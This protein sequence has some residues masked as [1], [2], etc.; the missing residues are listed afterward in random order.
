MSSLLCRCSLGCRCSLC[1]SRVAPKEAQEPEEPKE[2]QEQTGSVSSVD[3]HIN[4]EVLESET[5]QAW[6][7]DLSHDF[8]IASTPPKVIISEFRDA[9]RLFG[10]NEKVTLRDPGHLGESGEY[11]AIVLLQFD[12]NFMSSTVVCRYPSCYNINLAAAKC[13]KRDLY[14]CPHHQRVLRN[15]ISDALAKESVQSSTSL[16][17]PEPGQFDGYTSL[18]SLLECTQHDAKN[19]YVQEAIL[20]VRNF[21]II[22]STVLNPDYS[23]L[24]TALSVLDILKFILE[25]REDIEYVAEKAIPLLKEVI[26]KILSAFGVVYTWV[27]QTLQNPG[28]PG[29]QPGAQIGAGVGGVIGGMTSF[30][31]GPLGWLGGVAAGSYLGGL[32]GNGIYNLFG[33]QRQQ[34]TERLGPNRQPHNQYLMYHFHGDVTGRLDLHYQFH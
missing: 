1:S 33:R 18:I 26:G 2:Q 34:E 25:N 9:R 23:N 7:R 29:A 24:G 6:H 5:V 3:G 22:T 30:A 16:E 27:S 8:R 13:G 28:Q 11:E 32:I 21:L 17:E 19:R 12:P 15:S 20:N 31:S 14:L 10:V 4:D